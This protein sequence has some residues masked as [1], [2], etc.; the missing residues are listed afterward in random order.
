MP[1]RKQLT[2]IVLALLGIT[3][4]GFTAA[5]AYPARALTLVVPYAAG[6]SADILPRRVAE[7]MHGSL[8]RPIVIVNVPG[9][10]GSIGAARVARAAPDGY[11]FGLGTW[12]THVANGAVYALQYD[13]LNDFEPIALL[14]NSPLLIVARKGVPANDLKGFIQWLKANPDKASQGTNGPGSVMHLAG[15]LFQ[16]ETVTRFQFVPYR[17]A[18]QVLPDLI[19]GNI[20]MYIGLPADL[21]SQTRAG[22]VKAYA[23]A[24]GRRLQSAPSIPTVDEAGWPGLRVSAWFGLW[25]P[26]G[27]PKDVIG[28]LNASIVDA[29]ADPAVR[30][31]LEGDLNLEIAPADQ[32]TP[33]GLGAYQRAEI[34]KWWPI[35]KAANIKAE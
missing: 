18:S 2:T 31:R 8:G 27:T 34:R 16:K 19:A 15:V 7:H 17:G 32:Q 10:A 14:A 29:L 13:V 5:Q 22:S 26:R 12:S 6:G 30:Q 21:L 9:A 28:K 4:P 35:I 24:A 25:A 33:E 3:F 23:V 1:T 20:D 11:T